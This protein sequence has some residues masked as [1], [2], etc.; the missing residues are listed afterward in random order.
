VVGKLVPASELPIWEAHFAREPW[1]FN[2]TDQ[3]LSK[4]ALQIARATGSVKE[5]VTVQDLMVSD[6][7]DSLQLNDQQIEELSEQERE[8]YLRRR[9]SQRFRDLDLTAE[10]FE[11]LSKEDQLD[12]TRRHIAQVKKVFT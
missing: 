10:D 11:L 8:Y 4:T 1:G 3:L 9:L 5:G 2:A 12:Y 7:Y 6:A